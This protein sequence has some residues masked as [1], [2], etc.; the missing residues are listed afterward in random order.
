MRL[1][2]FAHGWHPDSCPDSVA[3]KRG[4]G[5]PSPYAVAHAFGI[6]LGEFH[7]QSFEG[8]ALVADGICQ[9]GRVGG[10]QIG[11]PAQMLARVFGA[12]PYRSMRQSWA[13][14]AQN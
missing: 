5:G 3:P 10:L 11:S 6:G 9:P 12:P 8:F 2:A 14:S 13:M 4:R 7:D 1:A